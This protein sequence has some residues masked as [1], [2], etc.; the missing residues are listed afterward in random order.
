M[1]EYQATI[2]GTLF[3]ELDQIR[4]NQAM[5]A[6]LYNASITLAPVP[7]SAQIQVK[8]EALS[9]VVTPDSPVQ[10]REATSP[11]NPRF[12]GPELPIVKLEC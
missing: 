4:P 7:D 5:Q 10:R 1:P 8:N 12:Y 11:E 2:T 9:E 3:L 6:N